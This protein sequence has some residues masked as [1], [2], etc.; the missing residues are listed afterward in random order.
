MITLKHRFLK[1]GYGR[2]VGLAMVLTLA[3]STFSPA[4][5]A[6][7]DTSGKAPYSMMYFDFG[8]DA[9][10]PRG[11]AASAPTQPCPNGLQTNFSKGCAENLSTVGGGGFGFGVRPIRY[12]AADYG[13]QFLGNFNNSGTS[14]AP[15]QCISGCSG[16]VTETI[17]T[18]SILFTTDARAV[19]PLFRER[20]LLSAGGG[21][22]WLNVH[23]AAQTGNAQVQGGCIY[24]QPPTG[25]HGPTEIAEI[26]YLPNRHFGIGFHVRN[27]QVK[28]PGLDFSSVNSLPGITYKDRFWVI[29]GQV[30]MRFGTRH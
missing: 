4:L 1:W 30:S 3:F 29:G 9:F 8:G 6:Q 27:V 26:M 21:M 5:R 24:C 19:L 13:I 10:S 15:Y 7:E 14:T 23:Q 20:L 18:V 25:G 22:A 16:T 2:S 12:L 17:K 28:S 11:S